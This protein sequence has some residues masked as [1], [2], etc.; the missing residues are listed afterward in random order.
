MN[1]TTLDLTRLKQVIVQI[2]HVISALNV[3]PSPEKIADATAELYRTEVEFIIKHPRE[4]FDPAR[5]T[6][7]LEL[8]F[9]T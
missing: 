8:I 6:R 3:R 5:H 2:E 9:R 1:P 7:L 4:T